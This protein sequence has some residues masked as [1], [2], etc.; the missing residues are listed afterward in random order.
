MQDGDD[1]SGEIRRRRRKDHEGGRKRE[2]INGMD[3]KNRR[4][5]VL[6]VFYGS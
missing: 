5:R 3:Q 1:V 2:T 4:G 6:V